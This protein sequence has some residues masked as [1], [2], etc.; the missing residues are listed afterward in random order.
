[1]STRVFCLRT[2]GNWGGAFHSTDIVFIGSNPSIL[3]PS[4]PLKPSGASGSNNISYGPWTSSLMFAFGAR[5]LII[6]SLVVQTVQTS[7]IRAD[8]MAS[9]RSI[10]A[11]KELT[12][13]VWKLGDAGYWNDL[14]LCSDNGKTHLLTNHLFFR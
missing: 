12:T 11:S 13:L 6:P 10:F 14:A 4:V 5:K 8:V 7:A 2:L 3:Q 9:F 1:M